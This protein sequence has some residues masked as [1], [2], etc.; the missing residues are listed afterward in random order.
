V[1]FVVIRHGQSANNLIYQQTGG[2]VGRHHDPE[3]TDLG[4]L[5]AA[6]LAAAV[7]D[8]VL[9]W[10]IT[11]VHT[12]L[13]T[14][15][16]QTAAPL[17]DALELPLLG[18]LDAYETGGPFIE[19]D[20]GVR[21]PHPGARADALLAASRRLKLPHGIGH[22]GW[23]TR[24]YEGEDE[25][26]TARAEALIASLRTQHDDEAVV[27]LFTHG[28][29]FQY[30]FRALLGIERMTGWVIKHNTAISLFADELRTDGTTV[31]AQAIDWMPHLS[32]D[33]VSE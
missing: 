11:H 33:L 1:R 9:P 20:Q 31:T 26:R 8:G 14:R 6:R 16:V 4:R 5:Q 15:A 30:L 18:N 7:A 22:D 21:T 28:A 17:V 10:S 29:F 13:M 3:L 23:Y 24:P 25:S 27:A 2:T 12:S 19:D 32:D